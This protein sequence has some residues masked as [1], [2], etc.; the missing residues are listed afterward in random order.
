MGS[1]N[2]HVGSENP[3]RTSG[4]PNVERLSP[5]N[6]FTELRIEPSVTTKPLADP[7]GICGAMSQQGGEFLGNISAPQKF[8]RLIG[9]REPKSRPSPEARQYPNPLKR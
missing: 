2:I 9:C 7:A 8:V 4:R 3:T 1:G 5:D 6:G